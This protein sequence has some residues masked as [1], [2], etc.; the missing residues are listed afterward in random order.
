MA[1]AAAIVAAAIASV[2]YFI[3]ASFISNEVVGGTSTGVQL[4]S[5]NQICLNDDNLEIKICIFFIVL[6]SRKVQLQY[7]SNEN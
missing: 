7:N 6:V 1:A 2:F 4:M 5:F 3:S